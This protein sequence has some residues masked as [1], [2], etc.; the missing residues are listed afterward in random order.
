MALYRERQQIF[1]GA[2]GKSDGFARQ[3]DN[4]LPA[5]YAGQGDGLR[6]FAIRYIGEKGIKEH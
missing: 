2:C 5:A 3:T 4:D 1:A 6:Y